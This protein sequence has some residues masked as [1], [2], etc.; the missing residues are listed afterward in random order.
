MFTNLSRVNHSCQPN[1]EFVWNNESNAQDLRATSKIP[2]GAEITA[3]YLDLEDG[4]NKVYRQE[5]L[6]DN[7]MFECKCQCCTVIGARYDEDEDKRTELMSLH[8]L[9]NNCD[10]PQTIIKNINQQLK[11]ASLITGVK[12]QY[13]LKLLTIGYETM[14]GISHSE[15]INNRAEVMYAYAKRALKLCVILFG[16]DYCI[17]KYWFSKNKLD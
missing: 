16:P 14:A 6:A 9:L 1:A 15:E 11:L 12:T 5:F 10:T 7:F 13:C 8:H 3:S 4:L 17:T 2:A